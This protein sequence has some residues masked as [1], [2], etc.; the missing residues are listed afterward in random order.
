MSPRP[1]LF[2]LT[3]FSRIHIPPPPSFF[4]FLSFLGEEYLYNTKRI[5]STL[6]WYLTFG[7]VTDR[8]LLSS[9]G[10]DETVIIQ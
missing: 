3:I 1:V 6:V 5:P 9:C 8:I 7:N 4:A 10:F 2:L